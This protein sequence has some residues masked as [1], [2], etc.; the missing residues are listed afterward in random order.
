MNRKHSDSRSDEDRYQNG[1]ERRWE[2]SSR[3]SEQ[4]RESKKNQDRRR[5]KSPTKQK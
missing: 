3:Y 4:S 2:K 5:E 1:A